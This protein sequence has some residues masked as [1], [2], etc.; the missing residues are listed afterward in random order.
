MGDWDKDGDLDDDGDLDLVGG[1]WRRPSASNTGYWYLF[2]NKTNNGNFLKVNL[3]GTISNL[4]AVM[5]KISVYKAGMAK[6]KSALRVYREV[7]A[8][9]GTF[10]GNPLQ[11]HFGVDGSKKYDVVVIS[12]LGK[13][14]IKK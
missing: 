3:E 2:E 9:S 6:N 4:S 7:I 12:P 14:V 11:Q 10:P 8:G 5:S 13:E 1:N